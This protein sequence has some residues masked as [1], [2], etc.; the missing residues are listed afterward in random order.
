MSSSK[1]PVTGNH[2]LAFPTGLPICMALL[3]PM[4]ITFVDEQDVTLVGFKF[5]T[6][7]HDQMQHTT[8]TCCVPTHSGNALHIGQGVVGLLC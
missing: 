2:I 3:T 1:H 4:A 7:I 5:P 8:P 6:H